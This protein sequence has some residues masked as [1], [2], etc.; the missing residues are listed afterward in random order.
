MRWFYQEPGK[1]WL[2]FD[3]HD[4]ISLEK[5][6][7]R[8]KMAQE[9]ITDPGEEGGSAEDNDIMVMGD[10]YLANV[11]QRTLEPIYWTSECDGP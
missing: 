4:S 10:L 5:C 9:D 7:L 3:G 11:K 8:R 1:F 6:H 2:P